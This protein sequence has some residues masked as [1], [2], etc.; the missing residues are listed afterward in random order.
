MYQIKKKFQ[1]VDNSKQEEKEEEEEEEESITRIA[2]NYIQIHQ[3][4]V[5]INGS[6]LAKMKKSIPHMSL[7]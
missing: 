4:D 6:Q 1:N 2:S 5:I 3:T 7:P